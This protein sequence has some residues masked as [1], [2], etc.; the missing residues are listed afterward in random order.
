MRISRCTVRCRFHAAGSLL[1]LLGLISLGCAPSET[2]P[3]LSMVKGKA[4]L[5]GAPLTAG[6]V[7]LHPQ[8]VDPNIKVPLS[9]GQIDGSGNY[10]IFTGGK[11]GAP[12]GKYKVV[13]TPSMVPMQGGGT[14]PEAPPQKYMSDTET[15]LSI[16]VVPSP[17]EGQYDLKLSK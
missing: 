15:P 5:G 7:A 9:A 17:S 3:P 11:P 6:H 16:E 12:L 8:T 1:I 2:L 4:T 13:V 10:E 14:P